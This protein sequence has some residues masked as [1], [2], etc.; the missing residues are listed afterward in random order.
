M[1]A[2]SDAIGN[3][4]STGGRFR[5]KTGRYCRFVSELPAAR[6]RG[7]MNARSRAPE[8][9]DRMCAPRPGAGTLQRR[10]FPRCRGTGIA[11]LPIRVPTALPSVHE[12]HIRVP[13]PW[14]EHK[15][16]P[17]IDPILRPPNRR[18]MPPRRRSG[19]AIP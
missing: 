6:Q 17:A 10:G 16:C 1:R 5:P 7:V 12:R 4:R 11:R 2:I 14:S 3:L 13:P 15:P 8:P 9:G 19:P 18:A